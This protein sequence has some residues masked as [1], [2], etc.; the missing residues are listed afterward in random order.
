MIVKKQSDHDGLAEDLQEKSRYFWVKLEVLH[1]EVVL[2]FAFVP[3]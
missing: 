3:T 1:P 2:I